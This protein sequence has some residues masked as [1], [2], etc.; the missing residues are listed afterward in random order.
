MAKTFYLDSN[1]GTGIYQGRYLK[2]ECT[3]TPDIATNKSTI[4]WTLTSLGGISTYYGTGP[5]TL[6][7]NGVQVYYSGRIAWETYQFPAAKGS[8]S[9]TTIV[10]H[11]ADGSKTITVGLST[12]VSYFDVSSF[13]GTWTL[14]SIPRQAKIT[15]ASNFT[16][17]DNPSISFSNPG[18]FPMDVWLEPNPIGDHLC[19][20]KS[21][22]NTGSYTWSLSEAERDALRN[23][24]SGKTCTIRLGLYSNVGGV[25]YAD[26]RDMTYTMTENTATKPAVNM[27]ITLNNG[28]IPSKFDGLYIQGKSRLKVSLSAAGKYGASISS[29]WAT[30][31]GKTY[32]GSAFTSD[33]IQGSGTLGIEGYTR[34]SRDFTG[35]ASSQVNVI[36]YSKPLVIP[37][38]NENAILCYRSDGNGQRTGNSTSVWVKAAR[39][40]HKVSGNNT[41]ALQWRRKRTTEAWNDSTHLWNDLIAKGGTT[42]EYNALLTGEVFDRKIAYTIQI[43]AIDDIGEHDIKTFEVPTEDVALHLG[44]GGKNVAVGTYCD[45]SEDYT[46]YS[47][48][49]AIFAEGFVDGH[50]TG[51][52]SINECIYYRYNCGHVTIV[53]V[54]SSEIM[55]TGGAYTTVGTIP[56]EYAPGISIPIVCH[57]QGGDL[58][59]QAGYLRT[60]GAIELYTS[61][62]GTSYWAF[63]VTYPV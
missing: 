44:R 31:E 59:S 26:Y 39:Y 9:G 56:E 43:R 17:V 7:I 48:W 42:D 40:Y 53:G 8:V 41:C 30:V 36:A 15:A 49:K 60:T 3:Q 29:Y 55:L 24:C 54:S 25:I 16:D 51:W 22:P 1:S 33:A 63:T 61:G 57:F 20:R 11:N 2:V 10:D 52:Q 37:L 47:A 21:I 28:Q 38:A 13:S 32:N 58:I 14:D 5:T 46:F 4:H 45:Y 23:K 6:T 27:N 19:E 34:D 35:Y 50:D 18:G 12:A 62:G